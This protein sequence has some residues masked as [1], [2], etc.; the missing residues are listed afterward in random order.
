M[1]AAP[2]NLVRL[3]LELSLELVVAPRRLDKVLELKK[4]GSGGGPN[5]NWA[6]SSN[7]ASNASQVLPTSV[8]SQLQRNSRSPFA[9]VIESGSAPAAGC[10]LRLG[11]PP[12]LAHVA[13]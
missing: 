6:V 8:A 13:A 9:N 3:L 10:P 7:S 4:G 12:P 11:G 5:V 1:G 2:G